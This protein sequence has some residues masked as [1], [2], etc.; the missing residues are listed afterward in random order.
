MPSGA[1][2]V[3]PQAHF[4]VMDMEETLV[5]GRCDPEMKVDRQLKLGACSSKTNIGGF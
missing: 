5:N 1:F 2:K 3:E 4:T